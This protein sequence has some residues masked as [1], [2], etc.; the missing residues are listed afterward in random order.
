MTRITVAYGDGIGPEIMEATLLVLKEAGANIDI[1]TIEVGESVYNK[2]FATGIS[3]KSLETIQRNKI[4]LKAPITTPQGGGYKSLNVATRKLFG[5]YANVRPCKSFYPYVPTKHPNVDIV[6][7]RENEE[8]LY[9]GIEYRQTQNL[10]QSLKI[11]TRV[12]CERIVRFAFD[13]AVQNNRKKITCLSKDNI[14]KFTDGL[15]HQVFNE[16]GE[17]YP[18]IEKEHYIVDIGAARI[19]S[20]PEQF[21]MIVAG[22]L[23]GDI[24][25]DIAAEVCGSIGL[26]GSANIGDDFAMFEAVHGS[27]PRMAGLN[28]ANPSGLLNAA[29]MMLVHIGQVDVATKIC[30]AWLKTLEDGTHT[31]D[32]YQE[33]LSKVKVGTMEFAKAVVEN[34]GSKPVALK[35][36]EHKSVDSALTSHKPITIKRTEEKVLVGVD[37]FIDLLEDDVEKIAKNINGLA[38]GDLRLQL[39]SRKGLKIWPK[40]GEQ[41]TSIAGD[42]WRLRFVPQN[43]DKVTLHGEIVYLLDQLQ[44]AGIDFIQAT[45]LYTFDGKLGFSL[46]HGE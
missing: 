26:A 35:S 13:Y 9:A 3:Q 8:D 14:M 29:I 27:A 7:V 10:Y 31:K 21:D 15:F 34:L 45:N 6:I 2:G 42:H 30:N 32:I 1:E 25:S 36:V 20:R 39:I 37:V 33:G 12:G 24:V 41:W 28:T 40:E 23:Y 22:N 4:F 38:D 18:Q 44:K 43:K 19:A 46:A 16:I 5:L 11:M 17:Q